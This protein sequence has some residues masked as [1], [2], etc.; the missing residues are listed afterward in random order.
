MPRIDKNLNQI[1]VQELIQKLIDNGMKDFIDMMLLQE[2]A[3][4]TRK[5][6]INKSSCVREMSKHSKKPF[7]SKDL[8][9][10]FMKCQE[11]LFKD[12]IDT[13]E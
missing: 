1:E 4:Y 10:I 3:V 9:D 13:S 2:H 6:R 12:V 8:E 5:G 11:I 7:R